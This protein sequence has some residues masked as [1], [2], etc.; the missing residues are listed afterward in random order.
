MSKYLSQLWDTWMNHRSET[1][2]DYWLAVS[3]ELG[4]S[5]EEPLQVDKL[6]R[7]GGPF[8]EPGHWP[9]GTNHYHGR[10]RGPA[11]LN[12][13]YYVLSCVSTTSDDDGTP[14]IYVSAEVLVYIDRQRIKL[15][16]RDFISLY[17]TTETGWKSQGWQIDESYEYESW[18][19]EVEDE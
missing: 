6:I 16:D 15:P 1:D 10:S 11:L 13:E 12:I 8:I 3:E 18:G 14:L 5:L 17:Y 2:H 9:S 7:V 19:W 4:P